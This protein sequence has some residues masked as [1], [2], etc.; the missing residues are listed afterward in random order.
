MNRGTISLYNKNDSILRQIIYQNLSHR[1]RIMNDWK[2][3][4]GEHYNECYY[5]L[6]PQ[7]SVEMINKDGTNKWKKPLRAVSV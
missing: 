7:T 4:Y 6:F 1:R 3:L 2:K 5:Q